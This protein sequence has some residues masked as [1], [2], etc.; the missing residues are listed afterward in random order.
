MFIFLKI[1]TDIIPPSGGSIVAITETIKRTGKLFFDF[2]AFILLPCN[3]LSTLTPAVSGVCTFTVYGLLVDI[4]TAFGFY[5]RPT[6]ESVLAVYAAAVAL[7]AIFAV[8][9]GIFV[10]FFGE[11]VIK[12]IDRVK[13]KYGIFYSRI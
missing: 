1:I 13:L 2:L 5:A 10:F 7:N 12:K 6:P 3:K 8:S 11:P 4:W 9:M